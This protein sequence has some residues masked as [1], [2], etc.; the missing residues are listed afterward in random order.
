MAEAIYTFDGKPVTRL[1]LEK[2]TGETVFTFDWMRT[3]SCTIVG[4]PGVGKSS[5]AE[6]MLWQ[7]V[8]RGYACIVIDPARDLIDNI[9]AEL[10]EEA[11]EKTYIL[12]M[13]DE[14]FPF[15]VNVFALSREEAQV[16]A[17]RQAALDRVLQVMLRLFPG[18]GRTLL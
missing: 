18:E 5:L 14:D 3:A 16:V 1:G 2:F 11:L 10:P 17:L 4:L 7:D 6:S 13:S 8:A 9:V 15:G 12:D